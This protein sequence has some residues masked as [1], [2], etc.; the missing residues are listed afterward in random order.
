MVKTRTFVL[1]DSVMFS[2]LKNILERVRKDEAYLV[3]CAWLCLFVVMFVESF[4][5][6]LYQSYINR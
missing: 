6:I 5:L 1:I 4:E 2:L 3:W